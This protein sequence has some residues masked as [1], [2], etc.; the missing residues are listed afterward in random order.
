MDNVRFHKTALV[1]YTTTF[2]IYELYGGGILQGHLLVMQITHL[3][4]HVKIYE[5]ILNQQEKS[6]KYFF[7]VLIQYK[8]TVTSWCD[9]RELHVIFHFPHD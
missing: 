2:P 4:K 7:H 8:N 9:V 3:R 6:V 1:I 5:I